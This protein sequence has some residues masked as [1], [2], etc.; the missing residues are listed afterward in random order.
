MI[1]ISADQAEPGRLALDPSLPVLELR[2]AP[3]QAAVV[4]DRAVGVALDG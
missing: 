2:D 4:L 3:R 1:G